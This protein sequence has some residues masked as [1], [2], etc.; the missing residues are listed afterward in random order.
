MKFLKVTF[1]KKE[2]LGRHYTVFI[3]FSFTFLVISQRFYNY[4]IQ[5]SLHGI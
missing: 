1:K 5:I 3:S 4:N 2:L